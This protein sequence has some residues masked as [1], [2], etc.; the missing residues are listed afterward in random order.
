MGR[1]AGGTIGHIRGAHIGVMSSELEQTASTL[2]FMHTHWQAAVAE[3]IPTV[4]VA[5]STAITATMWT[6]R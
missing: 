1:T 3:V 2:P 6:V 4:A 5:T